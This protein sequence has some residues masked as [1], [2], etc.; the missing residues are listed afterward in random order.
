MSRSKHWCFTLNNYTETEYNHII[1][2][3]DGE[4]SREENQIT[5]LIVGKETGDSGT[6]HLQGFISFKERQRF[7]Q[8]RRRISNRAHLEAAR[9]SPLQA[10]EY[11]RKDQDFIEFGALPAGRGS[12]SDINQLTERIRDGVGADRIRD[13]FPKLFLR[14]S[15]AIEKW[16]T[17][18][19]PT[20]D[21]E[22][23]VVVHWGRTGT[24][25]TRS[26]FE[27]TNRN[28]IYVHPGEQWFDGYKGQ[29][30]VLFDDFNGSE[31]K[32]SYLLK[33][34]DRYPMKVPV[35]GNYV[36]WIPKHIFIT[37]NKNPDEWYP[38]AYEEHKNA[39]KRRITLIKHFT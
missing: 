12:R 32:L 17:D 28:A 35:K 23:N 33:L 20:R 15:R 8:V 16:C 30:V 9:G 4:N 39:L 5:Y 10:A 11:C 18:I 29:S 21:W 3:Y 22:V 31:F 38:H 24:G 25:K 14:Y 19:Q 2:L 36:N 13:E 26:V 34:L 1:Q 6:P 37:S 27:F 7:N